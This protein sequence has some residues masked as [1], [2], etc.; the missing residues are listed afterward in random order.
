MKEKNININND[1]EDTNEIKF[2]NINDID[3]EDETDDDDND[4]ESIKIIIQ[5]TSNNEPLAQSHT[6]N[7][8]S[9]VFVDILQKIYLLSLVYCCVS[10]MF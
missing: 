10:L 3:D 6:A 5:D 7:N 8:I 1:N 9:K 2:D 4:D